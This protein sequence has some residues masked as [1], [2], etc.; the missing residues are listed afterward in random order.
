M[1]RAKSADIY[2]PSGYLDMKGLADMARPFLFIAAARG[3]GKT[4]GACE[5]ALDEYAEI[6]LAIIQ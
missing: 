3:T 4:Y 6:C 2:L 1:S 5:Y